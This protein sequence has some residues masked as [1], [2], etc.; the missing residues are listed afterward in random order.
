MSN[1]ERL[2]NIL[3]A[4]RVTEKTTRI[5]VDR[6]YTFRVCNDATKDE[7]AKAVNLMFSVDAIAVRVCNVRGKVRKFGKSQGR[8]KGW[9]KAYVTLKEG[10][11]INFG[12]A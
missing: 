6:Q 2:M 5:Q 9:K 4:P 11:A 8:R 3:L 1:S 7:I 10:Q 12:G